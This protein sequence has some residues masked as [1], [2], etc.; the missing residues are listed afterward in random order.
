MSLKKRSNIVDNTKTGNANRRLAL[1]RSRR[2]QKAG[3]SE[4]ERS[5]I[6]QNMFVSAANAA[7]EYNLVFDAASRLSPDTQENFLRSGGS[8]IFSQLLR[9]LWRVNDKEL[10]RET[11]KRCNKQWKELFDH[12]RKIDAELDALVNRITQQLKM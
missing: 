10:L 3:L 2:L 8:K 11:L 9:M 6:H 1:L 7:V 5:A 12:A 4:A